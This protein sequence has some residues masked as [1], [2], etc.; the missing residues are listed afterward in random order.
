MRLMKQS[1]V[2]RRFIKLRSTIMQD[3]TTQSDLHSLHSSGDLPPNT[4]EPTEPLANTSAE[5]DEPTGT[6]TGQ[7]P[8]RGSRSPLPPSDTRSGHHAYL[9]Q[10]VRSY[11]IIAGS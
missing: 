8:M 2:K 6:L 10:S 5:Q 3:A 9:P 4:S 1:H 7:P 11:A